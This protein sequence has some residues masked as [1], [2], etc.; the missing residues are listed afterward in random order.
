MTVKLTRRGFLLASGLT[1][2]GFIALSACAPARK[3]AP[4]LSFIAAT[5]PEVASAERARPRSGAT[6]Q[7]RLSAASGS[8]DLGNGTSVRTWGYS[9]GAAMAAVG[10]VIRASRGDRL[11]V[12]VD[13]D[14]PEETSIHWHGVRIRND[15]DGSPPDT[16][17]PIASGGRFRYDFTVPDP[18]TY[19]YH[20]HSGLQADRALIGALIVE[21]PDEQT[22]ADAELVLVIDDWT[23]GI[24]ATPE[25][26]LTALT[27]TGGG[28]H[29]HGGGASAAP[30]AESSSAAAAMLAQ[31]VGYSQ[32]LG[33]PTQHIAYPMHLINGRSVDDPQRFDV[34]AGSR[35]RL[36]VI[37]AAAETPYRFALAGHRLTV[38]ATDGYATRPHQSD[39]ILIAP[40]QR[41]DVLADIASGI[42]P[43]VARV[44]GREGAALA[45]IATHDAVGDTPVGSAATR[46]PELGGQVVTDAHLHPAERSRLRARTPDQHWQLDLL[47]AEGRYLW[48]IG[49]AD[50]GALHPAVGERV[51]ISMTNRSSMWHPMH[52]HGHTFASVTHNGLRRDTT[53]VL[54]GQTV[55]IEFDADNP[56]HWMLHCH[57]AYH[58]A[59]GMTVPVRY[60]R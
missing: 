57:N 10:P 30:P 55:D 37:N 40:A 41:V 58:F 11:V 46:I 60:I 38:I 9:D 2:T 13:N 24:A 7:Y 12:D 50:A 43:F 42:W 16:Q 19:W 51:R 59:A 5:D 39:S 32:V 17:E 29:Q 23:D 36:R 34:A 21:D 49:G 47:E 35:V 18:G 14:L 3:A 56:G 4:M 53:I 48:G 28:G 20:S 1:A 6:V 44:E 52:L 15:M 8:A 45:T 22:A 31:G 25:Q 27:P 33:G 54:P 26:I